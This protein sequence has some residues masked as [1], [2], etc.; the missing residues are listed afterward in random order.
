M[1]KVECMSLCEILESIHSIEPCFDKMLNHINTMAGHTTCQRIY[2]GSSFCGQYFLNLSEKLVNETIKNCEARGIKVTL[3]LPIF[4]EK[5][6]QAGKNKLAHFLTHYEKIIDEITVNDYGMLHYV[7][8]Q[9]PNV[10]LNMGRLFMKDYR[11]PRYEAYFNT[12]LKPKGFTNYLKE[13]VT[14]LNVKCIEFDPTHQFID[15]GEH[16]K[17]V[18]IALYKPYAYMTVGQI[19]ELGSIGKSIEKKFR[20]NEPCGAECYTQRMR[21]FMEDNRKWVRVGRAIY[22]ENEAVEVTGATI[23]RCIYAPLDWEA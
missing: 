9:Y 20:P 17:S 12:V 4:T 11:E 7:H 15:F 14:S 13:I 8:Q 22:F 19:C 16:P 5:Y 1:E 18:E 2:L 10:G 3:V 23:I 6:L 21:Y